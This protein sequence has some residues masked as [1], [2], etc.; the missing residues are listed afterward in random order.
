MASKKANKRKTVNTR[1]TRSSSK[2]ASK[3]DSHSHAFRNTIL[4]I[5][6]TILTILIAIG[7]FFVLKYY[8][9]D[10][11][12]DV[13]GSNGVIEPT[14]EPE[15]KEAVILP[16]RIDFQ[17][18]VDSWANTINGNRSVL[19]YDLERDEVV[20]EYNSTESYNTASLYKLFVVY[21]GYRRLQSGTWSGNEKAG[22]T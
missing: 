15:K 18:V 11:K 19:I 3:S 20:G 22:Y 14:S 12:L 10:N 2:K 1:T 5:T 16:D 17:P 13:D 21:E 6:A 7:V 4:I 9:Y 8:F